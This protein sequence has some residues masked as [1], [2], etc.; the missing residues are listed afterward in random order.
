MNVHISRRQLDLQI[1]LNYL[2]CTL[3]YVEYLVTVAEL[4]K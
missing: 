3:Y 1:I 2:C 4:S